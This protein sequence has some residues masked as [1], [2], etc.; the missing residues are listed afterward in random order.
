MNCN[1]EDG[2]KAEKKVKNSYFNTLMLKEKKGQN[3][4]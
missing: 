3:Q 4:H 1:E 2:E